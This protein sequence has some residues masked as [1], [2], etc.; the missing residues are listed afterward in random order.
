[1]EMKA[2]SLVRSGFESNMYAQSFSDHLS[3]N[4]SDNGLK[5]NYYKTNSDDVILIINYFFIFT[6]IFKLQK[7]F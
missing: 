5:L 4:G 2:P 3:Q 1:M 7:W 6:K